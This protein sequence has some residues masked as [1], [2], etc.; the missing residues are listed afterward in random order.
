[1]VPIFAPAQ[2]T[3]P[4]VPMSLFWLRHGF[5]RLSSD[6]LGP[7]FGLGGGIYT[8]RE[9]A[10]R[11]VEMN[12]QMSRQVDD[13]NRAY[14][15]VALG[16]VK[17]SDLAALAV[18]IESRRRAARNDAIIFASLCDSVA[19]DLKLLGTSARDLA[20]EF[21]HRD[22]LFAFRRI[23]EWGEATRQFSDIPSGHWAADAVLKLRQVGILEGYPNEQGPASFVGKPH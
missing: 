13:V 10:E 20:T 8:K 3:F 1:L 22:F 23:P 16:S 5:V 12:R 18:V 14:S 4:D 6:G 21:R 9:A 15:A 11:L 19:A 7:D 17:P 2:E